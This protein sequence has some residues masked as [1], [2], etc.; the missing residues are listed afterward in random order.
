MAE[1]NHPLTEGEVKKETPGAK[2]DPL[3]EFMKKANA[4]NIPF[5]VN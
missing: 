2:K 3:D 4:S 1:H 5:D